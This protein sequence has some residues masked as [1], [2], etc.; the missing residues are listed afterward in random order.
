MHGQREFSKNVDLGLG[1]E[2]RFHAPASVFE[3][4][5]E[6]KC[7]VNVTTFAE[8]TADFFGTLAGGANGVQ[9]SGQF[10]L[11]RLD[12]L[13]ESALEFPAASRPL[14]VGSTAV[15]SAQGSAGLWK[16]CLQSLSICRPGCAS[17]D[18]K[19]QRGQ[20]I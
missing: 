12:R 13:E 4:Q 14:L 20:M 3:A 9:G 15:V 5:A 8:K 6:G 17:F 11:A 18:G 1:G 2:T 19:T 10:K 16:L 7:F